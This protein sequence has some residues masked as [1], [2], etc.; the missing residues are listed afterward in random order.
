MKLGIAR[1][2]EKTPWL[3]PYNSPPMQAN[4]AMLN[5]LMFFTSARGPDAPINAWRRFRAISYTP[6]P[7]LTP[8]AMIGAIDVTEVEEFKVVSFILK[9]KV[10]RADSVK[11]RRIQAKKLR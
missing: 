7:A 9:K 4:I 2:P 11:S 6:G 10:I 3:Y 8:P 1:T 5:T